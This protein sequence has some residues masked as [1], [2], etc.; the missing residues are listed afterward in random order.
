[1]SVGV[2][3]ARV[4]VRVP[5]SEARVREAVRAVCRAERV[6]DA[7]ISVTFITNTAMVRMNRDFLGHSGPTDVITFALGH[8]GAVVGDVYVAPDVARVNARELRRGV[9]EEIVRLLVHGTL[10]VLGHEHPE[11]PARERSA[12]WLQQERLVA[13]I[14]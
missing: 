10:H 4:G 14:A 6:R 12:M 5:L 3:V 13:R 9:R 2:E 7:L 1:M 11:G 8:A